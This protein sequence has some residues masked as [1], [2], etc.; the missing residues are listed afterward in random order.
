METTRVLCGLRTPAMNGLVVDIASAADAAT[1]RVKVRLPAGKA[2]GVKPM[3]LTPINLERCSRAVAE[4]DENSTCKLPALVAVA[5]CHLRI[6][7]AADAA[8][9]ALIAALALSA[10]CHARRDL[11]TRAAVL[12]LEAVQRSDGD[13]KLRRFAIAEARDFSAPEAP[14]PS[15]PPAT[16]GADVVRLLRA[17][18]GCT[19]A[20]G[21]DRVSAILDSGVHAEACNPSDGANAL[22]LTARMAGLAPEHREWVCDMMGLLLMTGAPP[23]AR[24]GGGRTPLMNAAHSGSVA[25]CAMLLDAGARA[26]NADEEGFTALHTACV[27]L[28]PAKVSLFLPLHFVRILLTI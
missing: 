25:L 27:D 22:C 20:S 19:D 3:N 1:G 24:S 9:T 7:D 10:A 2:V 16:A 6:G 13:T 14:P 15:L 11:A 26:D 23:G 28:V 21:L 5:L 18:G 8:M 12:L 17:I 4:A